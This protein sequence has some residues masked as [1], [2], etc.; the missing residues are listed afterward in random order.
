MACSYRFN[1]I[2][3]EIWKVKQPCR[4]ALRAKLKVNLPSRSSNEITIYHTKAWGSLG[5]L[6]QVSVLMFVTLNLSGYSNAFLQELSRHT[7][8]VSLARIWG[9]IGIYIIFITFGHWPCVNM[10]KWPKSYLSIIIGPKPQKPFRRKEEENQT[11]SSYTKQW[12]WYAMWW[13]KELLATWSKK[14]IIFS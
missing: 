5:F 1:D 10:A 14:E 6:F 8:T 9:V 4:V 12:V 2:Y 11:W 13:Y 3:L 7:F